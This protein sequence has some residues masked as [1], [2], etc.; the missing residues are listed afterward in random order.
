MLLVSL[1]QM[2]DPGSQHLD[3]YDDCG[4]GDGDGE[5]F[6]LMEKREE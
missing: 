4:D 1:I 6:F 3:D 2:S 5:V